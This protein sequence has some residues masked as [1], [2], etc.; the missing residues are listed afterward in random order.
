MLSTE[1]EEINNQA[2]INFLSQL[3]IEGVNELIALIESGFSVDKLIWGDREIT[4]GEL[5]D[6]LK[7]ISD[8]ELKIKNL[9][10]E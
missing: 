5:N 3:N 2:L 6:I 4:L 10:V 7:K 8:G 1:E 9:T